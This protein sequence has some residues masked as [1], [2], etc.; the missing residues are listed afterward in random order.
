MELANTHLF[1]TGRHRGLA[2]AG[3]ALLAASTLSGPNLLM[4]QAT[5]DA[6]AVTVNARAG[7]A[8]VAPTAL[9]INHAIWDP[10]LGADDTS[11]LLKSAGVKMMRYP[12]GSYGDIYRWE[13]HTAPGGFVAANTDFDTF[14]RGV[15]KVGAQPMIIVNY[16]TGTAEEAAGWVRHANITRGYGIKFWTVGNEN[17][18]NGHYGASWEA[19]NHADK[20]PAGY[21]NLVVEF[22]EA[23]KAVDPTIKVGAVLTTPANWPDGIVGTGDAGTWNRTVLSLAGPHIDFVDVHWYPGGGTAAEALARTEH[24]DDA[25]FLLRRQI[26]T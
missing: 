20:S 26:G 9:G 7:L 12:G 15:V 2:L 5:P 16:G 4:A 21:A 10:T 25:L 11:A 13:T 1:R 17:Y 18:G 14:M 6:V 19:D 22:A 24:V 3:A 23:M 8:S